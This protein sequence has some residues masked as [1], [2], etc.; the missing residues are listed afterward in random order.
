MELVWQEL[1]ERQMERTNKEKRCFML[2]ADF[3][4]AMKKLCQF[5]GMII[6]L[7]FDHWSCKLMLVK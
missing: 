5:A 7:T 1:I 6:F 3:A 2:S 4:L